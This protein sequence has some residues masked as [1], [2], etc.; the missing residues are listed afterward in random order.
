LHRK[1][2][3][4]KS[5]GLAK[6]VLAGLLALFFLVG[7]TIAANPSL[8][9][10]LHHDGGPRSDFCFACTLAVGLV[11]SPEATPITI[12]VALVFVC[13]LLP[14]RVVLLPSF[15]Y[16]LLPGRAPPCL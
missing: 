9:E 14:S 1:H 15:D 7:V 8:H 2:R 12:F 6:P 4:F 13:R 16:L 5:D 10:K 11:N 3:L